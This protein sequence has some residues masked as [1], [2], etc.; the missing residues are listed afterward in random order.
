GD[1][2]NSLGP[3][4]VAGEPL[5]VHLLRDVT[6]APAALASV[7][8]HKHAEL[9]SQWIFL[10]IC[11]G[12]AVAR[13]SL[14]VAAR[15]AALAATA[16]LGAL[17]FLWSLALQ[18]GTY[19]PALRWLARWKPLVRRLE[20]FHAPAAQVDGRI[21]EFYAAHLGRFARS[22]AWCFAGWCGGLLETWIL[23]RLLSPGAGWPAA[24]AIEGLAMTLNNAFLFIPGRVGT[25]E[26]I[27]VGVFL[28]VGLPAAQGAAY[29]VLRRGRELVWTIPGLLLL[30]FSRPLAA[31]EPEMPFAA[32]E[33]RG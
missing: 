12:V 15:V 6:G 22:V 8:I 11:V 33:E 30:L 26:G 10:S 2:A 16:G 14:P 9:L 27:R 3:G 21:S 28:L 20:R 1:A 18:R 24:F 13:F 25:A 31:E 4:S 29:A 32:G 17:L 23:L 5:K 7:T 19:S